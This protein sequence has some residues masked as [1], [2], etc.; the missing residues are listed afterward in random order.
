M[1]RE[2]SKKLHKNRSIIFHWI[3]PHD[4]LLEKSREILPLPKK[5]QLNKISTHNPL[6]NPQ[7]EIQ[8]G[9]GGGGNISRHFYR[10]DKPGKNLEIKLNSADVTRITRLKNGHTWQIIFKSGEKHFAQ[11]T[12]CNKHTCYNELMP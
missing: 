3:P 11:C 8:R 1:N 4:G 7:R 9:V 10:G 6:T 2:N 12:K 5:Q